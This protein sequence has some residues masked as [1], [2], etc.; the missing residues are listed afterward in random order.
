MHL[1]RVLHELAELGVDADLRGLIPGVDNRR[2]HRRHDAS[3]IFIVHPLVIVGPKERLLL[4]LLL[5]TRYVSWCAKSRH[6][7][8][9]TSAIALSCRRGRATAARPGKIDQ[10]N[11]MGRFLLSKPQGRQQELTV[12][13]ISKRQS[14]RYD[15]SGD[16]S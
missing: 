10:Q 13:R 4:Q 12:V 3:E 1:A 5:M 16:L 11:L 8:R 15:H 9:V 14:S 6:L 7:D 2:R